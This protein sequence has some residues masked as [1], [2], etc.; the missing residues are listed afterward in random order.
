MALE[1]PLVWSEDEMGQMNR[2]IYL[3]KKIDSEDFFFS[4]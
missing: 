1:P 4:F 2:T 3:K